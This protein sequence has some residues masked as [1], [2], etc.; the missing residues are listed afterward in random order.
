MKHALV[1]NLNQRGTVDSGKYSSEKE[2]P[3]KADWSHKSQSA[4][5]MLQSVPPFW[6]A[7]TSVPIDNAPTL[8]EIK[9]LFLK[10][11]VTFW[12]MR[13]VMQKIWR[14]KN[15]VGSRNGKRMCGC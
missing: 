11:A 8:S 1:L 3:F 15:S 13:L 12:P 4:A 14:S 9:A 7:L 5:A 2:R 10:D 6:F